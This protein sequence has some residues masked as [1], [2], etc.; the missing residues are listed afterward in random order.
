MT[1]YL[2]EM[3]AHRRAN[4]RDDLLTRLVEAEVDGQKLTHEE[5]LG[6]FQL[7]IVGGQETTANLINNAI[8]CFVEHP[9]QL[10]RVR[11]DM[12]LLPRAIEEVLRYRSPVQWLMR[13]PTRD[14]ELHGRVIPAG[15][16]VLAMLGSANRD[17]GQFADAGRF[18]VGREPNAH[19]AFGHGVHFCLG[20]ALSRLEA[21]IALTDLLG[22]LHEIELATDEP[23]PPRRA[24]H[25]HGPARLP[26]RFKARE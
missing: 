3:I 23:W 26:I 21:R 18:D 10:A 11:A 24:L 5:I 20:A 25:V 4:P 17:P 16:L 1:A 2:A 19:L 12:D 6:F 9:E 14:V 15:K 7:L 22:R 8:L 13:A